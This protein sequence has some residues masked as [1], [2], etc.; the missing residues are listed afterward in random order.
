MI[1]RLDDFRL[2]VLIVERGSLSAAARALDM[3]PGA[4]SLRLAAL[5]RSVEAQLLRRTTRSVQ[6]TE[7]GSR[8]YGTARNV[9]G[10]V[11]DLRQSL[12]G[13]DA[14]ALKGAIRVTAPWDIGR[15]H[16]APAIDHFLAEHPS[17]SISL[18]LSDSMLDLNDLG[19]DIAIRYGR[20]PDSTLQLRRVS[21]NR[22]L[23]VAS[24]AYLAKAGRPA[25]PTDLLAHNCIVLLRGSGRFDSWPF[26]VDGVVTP[27]RIS[28]DRDA[29][30]GDLVRRWAVEGKGIVLKAAWDLALDI[31]QGRLEPLLVEFCPADV[32]L[33]IVLPPARQR[34]RRVKMLAD[35]LTAML[36]RLD[37]RL[38]RIGLPP[39]Q[40]SR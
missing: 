15:N 9:L 23:P 39:A 5:E 36:R 22:R 26:T 18:M 11:D 27:L 25:R 4:V 1:E 32:D 13:E 31:E 29:N 40:S 17:V 2:F 34:P 38:A 20:L 35:H 16:V 19:V 24:P 21:T 10:A 8:F 33:Q 12:A 7:A 30:D 6:L 37:R 28:G 3:T 14:G